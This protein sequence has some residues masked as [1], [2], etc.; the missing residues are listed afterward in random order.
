VPVG[1][2]ATFSKILVVVIV[3]FDV[4]YTSIRKGIDFIVFVVFCDS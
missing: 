3:A 1:R 2:F 4:T